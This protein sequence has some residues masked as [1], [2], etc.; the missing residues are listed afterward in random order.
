MHDHA[1]QMRPSSFKL[2]HFCSPLAQATAPQLPG[3]LVQHGLKAT[4][5][6]SLGATHTDKL[7]SIL[8]CQLIH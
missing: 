6:Y 2:Y 4:S 3:K 1:E 8:C 5:C 7:S